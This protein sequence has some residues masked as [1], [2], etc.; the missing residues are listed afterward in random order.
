M[1]DIKLLRHE[2]A[3]VTANLKR[4][5]FEFDVAAYQGLE[6]QRKAVQVQVEEL[7]NQRNVKSQ[8]IGRAKAAGED[9]QPL[10]AAVL[11]LGEAL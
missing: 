10:M 2:V 9:V 8:G 6:E 1:L 4:R 11:S 3:A 5:G 7:R